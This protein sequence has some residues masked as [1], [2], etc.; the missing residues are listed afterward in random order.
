MMVND[1]YEAAEGKLVLT[2]EREQGGEQ[3]A[4]RELS[5]AIPALGQQTYTFD[6]RVP[7]TT[8]ACLLKASASAVGHSEPTVSRR[9][10]TVQADSQGARGGS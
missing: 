8:G 10:V 9:K 4:R 2:L 3:L 1:A 7:Q 5:F 6:L